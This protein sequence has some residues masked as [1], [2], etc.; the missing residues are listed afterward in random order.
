MKNAAEPRDLRAATLADVGEAEVLRLLTAIAGQGTDNRVVLGPG[1]D[2][3]IWR[4]DSDVDIV[5]TQ[6]AQIEDRD[7]R[8]VWM[9]PEQVGRRALNAALADIAGMGAR[10]AWCTATLCAAGTTPVEHVLEIQRGLVGAATESRCV[11]IGGD[12]SD[13][14]G[15]LVVDVTLG[16]TLEP[17]RCLRRD[18]GE[19][20]DVL[21][22]TGTL[23]RA[24]AGLRS[25]DGETLAAPA[26]IIATWKRALVEPE[27]RIA[28]GLQLVAAGVRCGGDISDGL[29]VEVA[30]TVSASGCAA[31]VWLD[32][33]PVDP[34]LHG[35]FGDAWDGIALGG[36]DDFE[37]VAAASSHLVGELLRAWPA[38]LAPV[39][40]VGRLVEGSGVRFL[41]TE[42]GDARPMPAVASRHWR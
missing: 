34:E 28:E 32:H 19:P 10:P 11:V 16:G 20:G 9:R 27:A 37:L 15:P 12:V 3:A 39:R 2:A 41:T 18:S 36:G 24:A 42:A 4:P 29:A 1:D 21:L 38:E 31:E 22:V 23:G 33:V 35:A 6:D 17:G 13:I 7:F 8:F 40:I 14:A 30:R 25:L 26:S 5:I